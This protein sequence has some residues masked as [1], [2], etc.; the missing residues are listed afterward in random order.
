M[1]SNGDDRIS[2]NQREFNKY[3]AQSRL[4]MIEYRDNIVKSCQCNPEKPGENCPT[5]GR[6]VQI[7]N[8]EKLSMIPHVEIKNEMM[9]HGK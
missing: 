8:F 4:M 1:S 6:Y 9:T 3:I 2:Q 5:C 7:V